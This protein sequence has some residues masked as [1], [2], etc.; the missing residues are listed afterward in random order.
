[1]SSSDPAPWT[2]SPAME[3]VGQRISSGIPHED[4]VDE[5]KEVA[6]GDEGG[7]LFV[8]A[9]DWLTGRQI[10]L[11]GEG[12]TPVCRVVVSERKMRI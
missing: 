3:F 6:K 8:T 1:M 10:G 12:I 2:P 4:R 9:P 11:L 5:A 7:L